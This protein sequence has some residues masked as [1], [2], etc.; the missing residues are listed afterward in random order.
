MGEETKNWCDAP[1][2]HVPQAQPL[3]Q[4]PLSLGQDEAAALIKAVIR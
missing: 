4:L 3:C 2:E 1:L